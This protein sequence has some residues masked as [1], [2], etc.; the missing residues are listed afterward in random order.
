MLSG[1]AEANSSVTLTRV[2]TGDRYNHGRRQRRLSFDYTGTSLEDGSYSFTATATDIAGNTGAASS[3]FAVTVRT[4]PTP[5]V[6]YVRQG[7]SGANNGTSWTDMPIPA[8]RQHSPS[9]A[10]AIRSGLQPAATPPRPAP[11]ARPASRSKIVWRSMAASPVETQLNER[12]W[13]SNLTSLS[14]DIGTAGDTGDN[15][16]HVVIGATGAT[17]DGFTISG[18]NANGNQTDSYGAGIYNVTSSPMLNNL[19]ISGNTAN[20][21]GGGIY[22]DASHPTFGQCHHQR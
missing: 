6:I 7:A 20:S 9:P 5:G 8:C 4:V 14:G 10:A 11:I 19:I 18:G 15:S 16:Y 2:G 1:T 13:T 22:N 17:L 21:A 12:N 3:D